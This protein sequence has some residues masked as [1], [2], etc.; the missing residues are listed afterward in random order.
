MP[1]SIESRGLRKGRGLVLSLVV[2]FL[3]PLFGRVAPAQKTDASIDGQIKDANGQVLPGVT[4]TATSPALLVPNVTAVSDEQGEYRLTPLPIGTYTVKYTLQGFQ[5][6]LE[7]NIPLTA[8]FVARLNQVMKVA[9]TSQTVTVSSAPPVVDTTSTT[10]NVILTQE[11][12][13]TIPNSA[14]GYVALVNQAPGVRGNLDVGGTALEAGGGGFLSATVFGQLSETWQLLEGVTTNSGKEYSQSGSFL[15]YYSVGEANVET[16][17]ANAESR[18]PGVTIQT[19]AKSGSNTFHGSGLYSLAGSDIESSNLTPAL[20]ADGVTSANT[21]VSRANWALDI[22]GPIKRDKLWFYQDV[23]FRSDIFQFLSVQLPNGAPA[24]NDKRETF[25]TSKANYQLNPKNQLIAFNELGYSTGLVTFLSAFYGWSTRVNQTFYDNFAKLEWQSIPR[26]NLVTSL[27]LGF[28]DWNSYKACPSDSLPSTMDI[29]T[30]IETGCDFSRDT[31]TAYEPTIHGRGVLTWILPHSR[32]GNHQFDVGFD[33]LDMRVEGKYKSRG[34]QLDYQLV[35]NNGV[36][37]ELNT[38][39]FPQSGESKVEY[40]GIYVQDKWS[41][42][43]RLTV[44][45]GLRYSH[46]DGLVPA[47]CTKNGNFSTAACYQTIQ[48]P[49][50]NTVAPRLEAA[51]DLTGSGKTVLRGGWGRFDHPRENDPEVDAANVNTATETTYLWHD[52]NGDKLYEPGEVNL[53]VNGPDF[54]NTSPLGTAGGTAYLLINHNEKEPKQNQYQVSLEREIMPNTTIRVLGVYA[55]LYNNYLLQGVQRPY[56]AYDIPVTKTI[57]LANGSA[58]TQTLTF[59]EYPS[60][61]MGLANSNTELIND[62]RLNKW[63]KSFEVDGTRRLTRKLFFQGSYATTRYHEPIQETGAI[64]A[65]NPNSFIGTGNYTWDWLGRV[66]ASYVFPLRLTLSTN[67]E[68]R[69]GV[70]FAR[71]ALFTNPGSPIPSITLNVEPL[72]SER[73]PSTN[74][75]DFRLN[76]SFAIRGDREI[77]VRMNTYNTLNINTVLSANA[78]SGAT[79]L[80]PTTIV[81]PRIFEFGASFK[82]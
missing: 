22:G 74:L 61:L 57:P 40:T 31:N 42:G 55:F 30:Q 82:F 2:L 34:P 73:D 39:N 48:F 18:T 58:G 33:Y 53:N 49:I 80:R 21:V 54:V 60:S 64:P 17:G 9:A 43:R 4:V 70:I 72:G 12:L 79:Y 16:A 29:G 38:D 69:S 56:S 51:W 6:V 52:L 1:I 15:D 28:A 44:N 27:Q 24:T 5:T 77:S 20:I 45:W 8:G 7:E 68:N 36:P 76:K 10:T 3:I 14:F 37:Y 32:I 35:F 67:F 26:T 78:R 47:Q 41:I 23:S 62:P 65:D 50:W 66:E 46:D 81:P 19:I 75:L 11:R 71:Q 25:L 63:Y 59:Y 13:Q